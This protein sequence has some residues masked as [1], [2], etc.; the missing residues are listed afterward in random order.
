MAR[1]IHDAH[2]FGLA[3]DLQRQ[4]GEAQLDG[5]LPLFLLA[6]PVGV[7]AGQSLYEGRFAVVYVACGAED[8]HWVVGSGQLSVVR[9]GRPLSMIFVGHT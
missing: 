5:H 9:R 2:L 4:P 1:H 3:A 6:Q 7:D 8:V